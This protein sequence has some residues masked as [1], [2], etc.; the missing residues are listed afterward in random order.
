MSDITG[1][2]STD[3]I[4]QT[5]TTSDTIN[6]GKGDDIVDAGAGSD[7]V[8]GGTG[9]DL[10]FGGAGNDT[11]LGGDGK[12]VVYGGSGNDTIGGG[13]VVPG[14]T[15]Q[16]SD[17]GGDTLYGD[18]REG[19]RT[20]VLAA[21]T[22]N[23]II[24]GGNGADTI[25]GDNGNNL[26]GTGVG[27]D[28]ILSGGNG[29]D[30]LYGE[31]GNDRL[32]GGNGSDVLVGGAGAD[33][34]TGGNGADRFVFN[35]DASGSNSNA[36]NL[37]R[38]TDFSNEDKIDL[39]S[40]L[41]TTTD[42]NWARAGL[43]GNAIATAN[44]V[45]FSQQGGNT[46]LYADT[47]GN[48]STAELQVLLNG[49]VNL[50]IR[51]FLGVRSNDAVALNDSAQV[52]EDSNTPS[53][54]NVLANDLVDY[55]QAL[56]VTNAGTY[57][58]AH[59]TL[60]LNANGSYSYTLNNSAPGVQSLAAGQTITD[61]F[62]YRA[63]AGE[64]GDDDH[65]DD[66]DGDDGDDHGTVS[67][68]L[69]ITITGTNDAP[70]ITGGVVLGDVA[71]DDSTVATGSLEFTDQDLSDSHSITGVT[72]QPGALGTLSASV[73]T[74]AAGAG[75]VAWNYVVDNA[76]LQSLAQGETRTETFTVQL[77]DGTAVVTRDISI[78]LTGAN[79]GPVI[80]GGAQSGAV[81]EDLA[82]QVSGQIVAADVDDGAVLSYSVDADGAGQ[83]GSLTVDADGQWHY[84]LANDTAAVQ[85]LGANATAIERFTVTVTDEH[86]A[87][88]SREV[89]I[90]VRG[91]NDGPVAVAD[92]A[93]QFN[94][95]IRTLDV[96]ANDTDVDAGDTRTLV[97]A[98]VAPG[99]GTVSIVDGQIQFDPGHDFRGLARD[100]AATVEISYTIEDA[101]G[102]QS[103]GTLTLSVIGTNT[104]PV[105][106]DVTVDAQEDISYTAA[107]AATDG[108]G[109]ALTYAI[110]D[111]P[112]H[113]TVTV[114]ADGTYTYLGSEN[115][116]GQDSFTYSVTD[117]SGESTSATVTLN[118]AAVNDAPEAGAPQAVTAV[119]DDAAFVVDLLAGATDVDEGAVL[120][121][122][123]FDVAPAYVGALAIVGNT[124]RVDPS[125]EVF[126]SLAPGQQATFTFSY[127]IEDEAGATAAT[128]Q[129][130]T[131][132]VEGTNDAPI[133][134]D[135]VYAAILFEGDANVTT[136][137]LLNGVEDVDNGDVVTATLT[138]TVPVGV[139]LNGNTLELEATSAV[140]DNLAEGEE[141]TQSISYDLVDQFGGVAHRTAIFTVIG[142]N[143][144][145]TVT[146]RI[147]VKA[148]EDSGPVSADLLS[149]AS[150]VD[151]GAVLHVDNV[152][153]F[154]GF[155]DAV[156]VSGGTLN[157][158][159]SAAVIQSLAA[160][161]RADIIVEYDVQDEYGV[162]APR[163]TATISVTG[164]NDGPVANGDAQ[165]TDEDR[166]VTID[167][168]ANDTDADAGDSLTILAVGRPAHGS[169][170]VFD[171][172]VIYTPVRDYNGDDSFTYTVQDASGAT[173]TATVSVTV[174]PVNDAPV[175]TADTNANDPLIEAEQTSWGSPPGDPT[176]AGNV[177]T[178]D[179][180][181]DGNALTV[182]AVNGVA[183]NVGAVITGKYGTITVNANGTYNYTLNNTDPDTEALTATI[184]G[185]EVF[186]YT[187]ADP[188]GAT[189]TSTLTLTIRGSNDR[190]QSVYDGNTVI[191]AGFN[192]AGVATATGNVLTND[193]DVDAGST[194]RMLS[195]DLAPLNGSFKGMYGTMIVMTNGDYFYTL[196]NTDPDT[197]ALAAGQNPLDIFDFINIVDEFNAFSRSRLQMTVRGTND[198]PTPT[199]DSISV[200]EDGSIVVAASQLLANDTDPDT[201]NTLSIVGLGT[202]ATNGTVTYSAA[203]QT[204]TYTPNANFNGSDSF[205]YV[206]K[207][208]AGATS[209]ATVSVTVNPVNDAPTAVADTAT[210]NEDTAVTINV[211]AND[212]DIDADDS[213]SIDTVTQGANGS[214]AVSGGNVVYTPNANY[215]GADSFSY[216]VKDTAGA[217]S[218]ATVNVTVNAVND[219]PAAVITP[220]TFSATEQTALSLKAN[221]LSV[222]DVDSGT[223]LLT[224]TLAVDSGVLNIA[225]GTSGATVTNSGSGSVTITGT[226]A[227]INSLLNSDTTSTVSFIS[228]TNDAPGVNLV[229][230]GSFESP[231]Y[232]GTR[233]D[234]TSYVLYS[235][236]NS[237]L[238]LP[239]WNQTGG[240]LVIADSVTGGW[241]ASDGNQFIEIDTGFNGAEFQ[242]IATTPGQQYRLTFDYAPDAAQPVPTTDDKMNVFINGTLVQTYDRSDTTVTTI[243]W[244]TESI[245]FTATGTS[246]EIRFADAV[247]GQ[248]YTGPNLD[249]VKLFALAP[250]L[251]MT[252]SDNGNSGS[253]G[254][255]I[256]S[257]SAAITITGVNDAPVN[258][259]PGAFSVNEDTARVITGLNVRDVDS[260]D[261]VISVKLSVLHGALTVTNGFNAAVTGNNTGT[262]T[263]TG[264]QSVI[265]GALTAT[266]N[267]SYKGALNY[268]GADTLT[269]TTID[270]G[271]N[272]TDPGLTG[273]ATTEQ[274]VD[275]AAIT[276][277]SLND[278]PVNT[279]PA[280]VITVDEDTSVFVNGL[281]V[282][283][284]DA[285]LFSLSVT[286]SVASGTLNIANVG[287]AGITGN[288][289]SVITLTGTQNIINS[290]LSA[291]NVS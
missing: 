44:G 231:N 140:Y 61:S 142:T 101:A 184:S 137:Y 18:G 42:L 191:E 225:A 193:F 282:S 240:S 222:S 183:G 34:L 285:G 236:V 212:T 229:T 103:T 81:S 147:L 267:I 59:G 205:T 3:V 165:T 115:Y 166:S 150:D 41:G 133:A 152:T 106:T 219:A 113:G 243:D 221:G 277:V 162:S 164:V 40:L 20:A 273:T 226:S 278:A 141:F 155:D 156:S 76:A 215:N 127:D 202:G 88:D 216:T 92:T 199:N 220:L 174:N 218:T 242:K 97:S 57:Q 187:V 173:S 29:A 138:G 144:A 280:T 239:G 91:T 70:M 93:S 107:F 264:T 175:A 21:A 125:A 210:T 207:D 134:L 172:K 124:L 90:T 256:S 148:F 251:T 190:P 130:V 10:L 7:T 279:A 286:L 149:G 36:T 4:V 120:H 291:N 167:V 136:L 82:T 235:I 224:V 26:T 96:I 189:S 179:T 290:A 118:V 201:G 98:S 87:S 31:G 11:L 213:K 122:T 160:G 246:T 56:H 255:L 254:T 62:V 248:P 223:D 46:M 55:G 263:L 50:S 119:E 241:M 238:G 123:N 47:D 146:G 180:D 35:A 129:M 128:R 245:T 109:D 182:T 203:S 102:A 284:V 12:D 268:N 250:T 48:T 270:N 19:Y 188:S 25:Y 252:V 78:T 257:D 71:E 260:G 228:L 171:G 73:A 132:T 9:S 108:E 131:I 24:S 283:D 17:N 154:G 192:V 266:N 276:V 117:T 22:G 288:G 269:M 116:N 32:D 8:L 262:V 65:D 63:S 5:G 72:A 168:L 275:T 30:A 111:G 135:L 126:Q 139:T 105:A 161:Q 74:D 60:V 206:M 86:G 259:V 177:L 23:D 153:V 75:T 234:G 289:T 27:G 38:I 253:G 195:W 39:V 37:D 196:D 54:G 217:T 45:W 274:D 258:T 176:A 15:G 200:N 211:L 100:Q 64:V 95:E 84:T 69:T 197:Q 16:D 185:S 1:T 209:T 281:S 49:N 28:D 99:H 53:S 247:V 178:N 83:Y 114:N 265:S 2:N 94:N 261:A 271:A 157:V 287:G 110:T 249:N 170:S 158:D 43:D 13:N 169:A 6:A 204:F 230:N 68:R 232:V 186:N 58:L 145:P 143:D 33:V 67:A 89:Q 80:S 112:Q 227:Q 181:V 104:A 237:A 233:T 151:H 214:V 194:I 52:A 14:A 121:A 244:S 77:S 159:T 163:Q 272:G 208:G 198:A 66:N 51:D 85:S 79:D